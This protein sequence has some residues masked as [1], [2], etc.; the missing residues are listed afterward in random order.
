MV[1][2]KKTDALFRVDDLPGGSDRWLEGIV[3]EV[4][5]LP[6]LVHARPVC[7]WVEPEGDV[8]FFGLACSIWVPSWLRPVESIL[9]REEERGV[10][11]TS[12]RVNARHDPRDKFRLGAL[13][14]VTLVDDNVWWDGAPTER[15]IE[16]VND[17]V[18]PHVPRVWVVNACTETT[19]PLESLIPL[20]LGT[21]F[22]VHVEWEVEGEGSVRTLG[23]SLDQLG[24]VRTYARGDL[25]W[26]ETWAR[27]ASSIA[28]R[29]SVLAAPVHPAFLI[30]YPYG[31]SPTMYSRISYLERPERGVLT[32]DEPLWSS[33]GGEGSWHGDL[34]DWWPKPR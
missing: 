18:G 22:H 33:Q 3:D 31:L 12:L 24:Q 25:A 23:I 19:T 11:F 30:P 6:Q 14:G 26:D 15:L 17:A 20:L 2:V 32:S 9:S 10:R 7:G 8:A 13:A 4:N 21:F 1:R 16:W 27:V 29:I 5:A 28:S 34:A